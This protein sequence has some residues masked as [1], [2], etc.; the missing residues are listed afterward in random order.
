MICIQLYIYIYVCNYMH[1][2]KQNCG[3]V[4][5]IKRSSTWENKMG[6]PKNQVLPLTH[7]PGQLIFGSP[8]VGVSESLLCFTQ[9]WKNKQLDRYKPL[10]LPN[11]LDV[12]LADNRHFFLV[13]PLKRKQLG[14]YPKPRFYLGKRSF[15]LWIGIWFTLI[16]EVFQ[17]FGCTRYIYIYFYY[18]YYCFKKKHFSIPPHKKNN[19]FNKRADVQHVRWA[20]RRVSPASEAYVPWQLVA[21]RWPIRS[22]SGFK[23]MVY[24]LVN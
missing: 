24:P 16:T 8:G 2:W 14:F 9:S 1:I 7:Q 4:S 20:L 3:P 12:V 19:I 5:R 13:R 18:G 21:W 11:S 6:F 22:Q 17:G 10:Q 15:T 23:A